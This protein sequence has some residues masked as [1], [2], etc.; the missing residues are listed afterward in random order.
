VREA[1]LDRAEARHVDVSTIPV[2]DIADIARDSRS[3]RAIGAEMLSAAEGIGFFYIRNTAVPQTLI[4]RVLDISRRFFA[5]A[6]DAK[7]SVTVN[8][9]HRGFIRVGEAKMTENAQ[10][11]LKESFIWGLDTPGEDG[12]PPNR[13]PDFLPELRN[14]LT[15][16]FTVGNAVGWSLLRAVATALDISPDSFVRTTDRPISRGSIIYY[17]EQ[18]PSGDRFGVSSHT[19]YGCL[20]LL[21]Q[22]D[23]GGLQVQDRHGEWLAAPP[24]EGSFVVN[25]GD[26]LARWSNDRFRS[27]PHRVINRSGRARYSTALFVDPNR[28]TLI[29]PVTRPGEDAHYPSTTCENYLRSRLDAAFDYRKRATAQS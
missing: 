7:A 16:F 20:T 25:V 4:D 19:D 1:A 21:Y 28:D 12:I 29:V 3:E 15:T 27:T 13:W 6:P 8:A 10:P 17:P 14:V 5:A 2:I 23:T 26:L 9:G 22:D 18:P 11:D 24:I